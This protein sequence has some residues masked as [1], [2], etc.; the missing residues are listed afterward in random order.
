MMT[1]T[2]ARAWILRAVVALVVLVL[3]YLVAGAIGGA[4]PT[5][6]GWH[7][8]D[9]G[10]RI[11]VESN[12]VHTG[13]VMPKVAAGV[14]WRRLAPAGD[15]AD[16]RYGRLDHVAIG[17]GEKAFFLETKTWA[18]VRPGT[19]LG[20]AIGSS[21]TLMH[22]E[23]VPMPAVGPDVRAVVLSEAEYRRLAAFVAGSFRLGGARYPGYAGYDV[24]YDAR[25]RYDAARTCNA[26][27]GDALRQAGVRV[28]AWT[29]FP[30]TVMQWFT[31]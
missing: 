2:G 12:G 17:W 22:V 30:A 23:H 19:I 29:P 9:Q 20:A 5:N 21:H 3:G 28:G 1:G 8:A 27:T 31:P 14:D 6:R 18:D 7:P 13:F 4:I 26:W 24:F 25:G 16:P 10:V 11:F 15:L